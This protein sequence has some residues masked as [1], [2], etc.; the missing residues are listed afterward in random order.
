MHEAERGTWKAFLKPSLRVMAATGIFA[1]LHSGLASNT[2]KNAVQKL[3]GKRNRNGLYRAA[4]I[5]QSLASFAALTRY[6]RRHP[7]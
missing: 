7:M 5:G 4:Y 3:V 6:I 2:A 1:A